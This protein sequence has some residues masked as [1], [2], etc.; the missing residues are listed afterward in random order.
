MGAVGEIWRDGGECSMTGSNGRCNGMGSYGTGSY[1]TG[2][3][4]TGSYGT[5]SYGMGSYGMGS[6]GMG[7]YGMGRHPMG[8]TG[9]KGD[10]VR[11][12]AMD[13]GGIQRDGAQRERRGRGRDTT[14]LG[15]Q[16][17]RGAA[18]LCAPTAEM[19]D[20]ASPSPSS[21][22]YPSSSLPPSP[23]PTPPAPRPAPSLRWDAQLLLL[24]ALLGLPAN[25]AVLWLTGRRLRC[26]GLAAF[27][28]NVAASDFL[29]LANGTLQVWTAAHGHRWPLGTQPCRLHRFLLD[30]AYYGGLLLLAAVS[31][32]RCALLLAPLWYRCRRPARWPAGLCG[33]A[34]LA[35]A[36]CS[37]PNA[38]LARAS[39]VAPGLVV[40]RRERGRWESALGWLEAAVEGLLLPAAVLLLCHAVP[41]AVAAARRRRL[42]GGGAPA[43]FRRLV[44]AT[45]GAYLAVNL[46]FQLARL[47]SRALPRHGARWLYALGLAFYAGS[48]VNPYLYLLLGTA[49]G[50]RAASAACARPC[51]RYGGDGG[52]NGGGADGPQP[53]AVP[54]CTDRP[55]PPGAAPPLDAPRVA[56][57]L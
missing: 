42:G 36:A 1:G 22:P 17:S 52:G 50:H 43:G 11:S 57:P 40:C 23:Y 35:A 37:A 4:G 8:W 24:F 26:R 6:Y 18:A 27:V 5:G 3:Y 41:A 20:D 47:L 56:E 12:G 39:P 45:L 44:A 31:L 21:F 14:A 19:E 29:L 38:A 28:F 7:S 53:A 15:R 30:L 9:T 46:P 51:R 34:W 16:V 33:A 32:D 54:L 10:A 55:G 13:W 25:A 48:C 49:M 2:S